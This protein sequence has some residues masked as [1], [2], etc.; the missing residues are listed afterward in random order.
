M[1]VPKTYHFYT[2]NNKEKKKYYSYSILAC[3]FLGYLFY[4]SFIVGLIFCGLTIKGETFFCNYLAEKRCTELT[5]QFR[6]FLYSISASISAGRQMPEA[7]QEANENLRLI[8]SKDALIC[9]ELDYMVRGIFESK[10]PVEI[11]LRD[12][13]KRTELPDIYQ[14]VEVYCI[15]KT[16]GGN[17]Q[18]VIEKTVSVMIDKMNINR[19]IRV[20]TVQK[21]LESHILTLIPLAIIAFLNLMSPGYLKVLYT[22]LQGRILMTAALFGIGG[23]Y[24][25]SMKLTKIELH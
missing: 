6:D 24:A 8:Y 10:L 17:L 12:F 3:L 22:T 25:W 23:A 11:L 2:L 20:L 21:R 14:F 5:E 7:L 18:R 13:A 4:E 9:K 1:S 15:C 19:E 16:T